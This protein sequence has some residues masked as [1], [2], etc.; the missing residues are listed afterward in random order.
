M[1]LLVRAPTLPELY[2]AAARALFDVI[3]DVRTVRAATSLDV[4]VEG[5]DTED[6]LV[7]FLSEL[8]FLHDAR[9]WLFAGASPVEIGPTFVRATLWGESFDPGRHRIERQ[10]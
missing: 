10:V 9:D 8:L 5:A 2:G 6:L 1:A 3:L 7:R 4:A